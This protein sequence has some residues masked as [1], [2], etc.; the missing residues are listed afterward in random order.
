MTINPTPHGGDK[1]WTFAL[2]SGA[3][4]SNA[5]HDF[6]CRAGFR[7]ATAALTLIA[8]GGMGEVGA[9]TAS[10]GHIVAAKVRPELTGESS[11]VALRLEACTDKRSQTRIFNTQ[12]RREDGIGWIIMELVDGLIR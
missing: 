9:A 10:A 1:V 12:I 6:R 4:V 11:L 2:S 5:T 8:Q 7:G 3:A